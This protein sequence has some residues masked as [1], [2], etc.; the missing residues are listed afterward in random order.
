MRCECSGRDVLPVEMC[1]ALRS[2]KLVVCAGAWVI[3]VGDFYSLLIRRSA[4]D[5]RRE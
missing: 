1:E 3:H 2:I 5:G 4:D